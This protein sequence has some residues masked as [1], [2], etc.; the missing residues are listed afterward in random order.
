[1]AVPILQLRARRFH[2]LHDLLTGAA[3]SEPPQPKRRSA[4]RLSP[5]LARDIGLD[6]G[7]RTQ[8]SHLPAVM[9][10]HVRA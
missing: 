8:P 7:L 2:A 5:Y 9:P 3:P 6:T 1:M 4:P 10:L